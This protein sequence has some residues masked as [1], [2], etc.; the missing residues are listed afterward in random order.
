MPSLRALTWQE[1]WPNSPDSEMGTDAQGVLSAQRQGGRT[2]TSGSSPHTGLTLSSCP[3]AGARGSP[4]RAANITALQAWPSSLGSLLQAGI[5]G[6][7][8]HPQPESQPGA[9]PEAP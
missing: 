4:P 7:Q 3:S 8:S 5:R 6:L 1:A 9:A 2:R